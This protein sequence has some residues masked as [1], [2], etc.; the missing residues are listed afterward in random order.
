VLAA[1]GLALGTAALFWPMREHAFLVYDDDVYVTANP[2]VAAGLTQEGVVWAFAS[3]QGSNWFPLTRLS[4]MLDA[5][6]SGADPA[7]FHTTSLLLH[8]ATTA[9]LF[10]ALARLS[11]RP[12]RSAFVAAV[13]AAHPLHVESVAWISARKDTLSGLFFAA[14]LLAYAGG[15]GDA[16]GGGDAA[17]ARDTPRGRLALVTGLFALGLLAKQMLVTLPC[18]LLLLDDW[19]LARL[20]RRG[21]PARFDA[22]AL[23]RALREKLP[24]FALAAASCAVAVVAQR[25]GGSLA[26][27]EQVPLAWRLANA[28][29]A[30]AAYLGKS[31][32][33]TGLAVF[34]PHPGPTLE[35]WRV[36]GASALV[37]GTTALACAAAARRPSPVAVG[38]LWFLG[39]LVPVIGVV[40][41]G[42]QARA[43]RYT[44][45]PL[46]GLAVA[47]AWGVPALARRVVADVRR[48]ERWLA[49]AALAAVAALGAATQRELRHW[50][51]SESLMRR[52]L[53]VTER[54]HI[55]HAYLGVV[56]LEQDRV[57]EAIAHWREAARLA[58]RY[59]TVA[60]N[61]AWLLATAPDPRHRDPA[62][63]L[64]HAT[65]AARLAPEDPAVID[66]LAAALAANGRHEA[67][68]A[69]ARRAARL[70]REQGRPDLA[71]EIEERRHGQGRS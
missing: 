6:L 70:A 25:A 20:R 42:S 43:D 19:P 62:E 58:P 7:G 26:D 10:L 48:R 30:V 27:L 51:D 33:P 9:L 15:R 4:W 53:A 47:V 67:A 36:A 8:A 12:G 16:A 13:F 44:Y 61:L 37:V 50:R 68:A 21:D 18:V 45:L 28:P 5:E 63:A 11:G 14:A 31:F 34:Y 60:N 39:M 69:S 56:L 40:Q 2:P 3:L 17:G 29:V 65:R 22:A 57:E 49:I 23:A 54:N 46:V 35:P 64:V 59:V 52:A 24:L 38:W 55:A 32:L 71:R 66:T 41:V 1:A